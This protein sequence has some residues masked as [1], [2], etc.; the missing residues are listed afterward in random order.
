M[1]SLKDSPYGEVQTQRI[2][3]HIDSK[4][5]HTRKGA[6]PTKVGCS[7]KQLLKHWWHYFSNGDW[8]VLRNRK[9]SFHF[10]TTTVVERGMSVGCVGILMSRP[11]SGP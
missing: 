6:K 4:I 1:E 2:S 7:S 11:S 9:A 5:Q 10:K 8:A 3:D